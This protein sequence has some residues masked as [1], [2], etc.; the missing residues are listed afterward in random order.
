MKNFI[1][2]IFIGA[3]VGL[4]L[5][6]G[7]GTPAPKNSTSENPLSESSLVNE[8]VSPSTDTSSPSASTEPAQGGSAPT[9]SVF[10]FSHSGSIGEIYS[11]DVVSKQKK[12]IYSDKSAKN[13]LRL[14]SPITRDGDTIIAFVSADENMPGQLVSIAADGSNK[15]SVLIDGFIASESPV[16]SPDKTRLAMVSFSNAEPNYG[17]SLNLSDLTGKNKKE[18]AK[19]SS[20]ISQLAFSPNGKEIAYLKGAAA[21]TNE[22]TAVNIE[23]GKERTLYKDKELVIE[24]FDW[25]PID[26]LTATMAPTGKKA[27]SQ[28]EVYLIDPKNGKSTRVSKNNLPERTPKIAPDGSGVAYVQSKTDKLDELTKLGDIIITYPDGTKPT[29]LGTATQ[30]LGWTK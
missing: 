22:I 25:S 4:G 19:N 27:S 23:T 29:N 21:S 3:L 1:T 6:I 30:L 26:I 28:S 2:F 10:A 5:L 18:I 15:Q 17:F 8:V 12:L 20:G 7:R 13:K 11:Y 16:V 24:D 9:G 14:V